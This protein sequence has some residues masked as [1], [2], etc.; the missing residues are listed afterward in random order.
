MME[1]K[2]LY[3]KEK[4]DKNNGKLDEYEKIKKI[5]DYFIQNEI[6]FETVNIQSMCNKN[7]VNIV[8]M[9]SDNFLKKAI[10][11]E[12]MFLI[13]CYDD[14]IICLPSIPFFS[15][16]GN[17]NKSN[18]LI[19]FDIGKLE[20]DES[21]DNYV[22][23][24][25]GNPRNNTDKKYLFISKESKFNPKKFDEYMNFIGFT[26]N[27]KTIRDQYFNELTKKP[28]EFIDYLFKNDFINSKGK[29]EL[30]KYS[31]YQNFIIPSIP[32]NIKNSVLKV[33]NYLCLC[34]NINNKDYFC[35][36][37]SDI[38]I[39][40]LNENN[41][42]YL[43]LHHLIP[44]KFFIKNSNNE[45]DWDIIHNKINLVPLCMVC[46]QSI[47]KM[48]KNKK[49]VKK[50]FDSI[51]FAYKELNIYD[52][53]VNFLNINTNINIDTL[54]RFYLNEYIENDDDESKNDE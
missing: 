49:L 30:L 19:T 14:K 25:R 53:F 20:S 24:I 18:S 27:Q 38:N 42:T 26:K 3:I 29:L 8:R 23:E 41:L 15:Y 33:N 40:Y 54:L 1:Q 2:Y 13:S 31:K 39:E 34:N 12:K 35:P 36:C 51:I 4:I 9:R 48:N 10:N 16:K 52:D 6:P 50:V 5:T 43:H 37:G 46:H 44:K 17:V 32:D 21:N 11:K 22:L 28:E 7:N 47:H 45:V